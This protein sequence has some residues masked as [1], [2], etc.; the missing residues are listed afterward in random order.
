ME[1]RADMNRA[2]AI[3]RRV[4]GYDS[5]RP[6]QE[7]AISCMLTGRDVLAVLPTGGGKSICYQVPALAGEGVTIVISPLISLMKDQV[8]QLRQLGVE[9]RALNSTVDSAEA[10]GILR[11]AREGDAPIIYIA[12]ERLD[13][14]GSRQELWA[15][16]VR[17][18]VVD[19]AHCVSQWGHDFRTSYLGIA[20]FIAGFARRPTVAA[21]TATATQRVRDDIIKLLRL[22][23]P[24]LI[25]T[26]FDRGNLA[27]SVEHVKKSQRAAWIKRFAAEHAD[28]SGIVYC[29]SRRDTEQL[30]A[31]LG[32]LCYHAGLSDDERTRAQDDFI[33]DVNPLICATN[34]FGMGIDKPDVRFVIHYHMPASIEAYWQEAGRAGRDGMPA[35]CVLLGTASDAAFWERMIS[36]DEGDETEKDKRRARLRAMSDY[37]YV[38]GCLRAHL[39]RY[40]GEEIGSCGI[41]SNC[42]GA[43]AQDITR[44]AQMVLSAVRRCGERVGRAMIADVLKGSRS[45]H[46]AELGLD[47]QSTYGLM[48]GEERRRIAEYINV[49]VAQGYLELTEGKYPVLKLTEESWGVLRGE[50][51]VSARL[52]DVDED[53]ARTERPRSKKRAGAAGDMYGTSLF[54]HLRA[55]RREI[56]AEKGLPAF[57]VFGDAALCDM[58]R[59]A[60]DTPAQMLSVSGVGEQKMR[61][62]G[63]RFLRAI[64]EFKQAQGG[65]AADDGELYDELEPALDASKWEGEL[66]PTLTARQMRG[67]GNAAQQVNKDARQTVQHGGQGAGQGA[68][69][70][71]QGAARSISVRPLQAEDCDATRRQKRMMRDMVLFLRTHADE[72]LSD[73]PEY[74]RSELE[75]LIDSMRSGADEI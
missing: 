57:M 64:R 25:Q 62:Y 11:G 38:P 26:G 12:P 16:D 7:R 3:L 31:E 39:V 5:F 67:K 73:F 46:I 18:V 68:P 65:G 21:F 66:R 69:Q 14:E 52:L 42:T 71:R 59:R 63:E 9:A 47:K 32:A 51:Q 30:A 56:A 45:S 61:M 13:F 40:F 2:K 70:D 22:N 17:R 20:D 75:K 10:R 28:M 33:N 35:E 15:L 74:G 54:E 58:T 37:L 60:P 41:C 36:L 50:V 55:L 44:Q 48:K 8:D 72:F 19:E 23:N 24:E 6:G 1:M 29:S 53:E 27:F 4:F 43:P 34:A 49:L